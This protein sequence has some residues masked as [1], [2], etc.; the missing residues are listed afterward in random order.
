MT[1]PIWLATAPQETPG[2]DP[3]TWVLSIHVGDVDEAPGSW[4][5]LGPAP[6]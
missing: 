6:C 2:D 3:S 4:F 1:L 5:Q